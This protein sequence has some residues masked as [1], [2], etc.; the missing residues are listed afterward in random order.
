MRSPVIWYGGKSKLA[1]RIIRLF[2]AHYTYVEPCFGGGSVFFGKAPSRHEVVNDL[3]SDIVNFFRVLRDPRESGELKRRLSL[4]PYSREEHDDCRVRYN[5]ISD[6]KARAFF[7]LVR[8]SFNGIFRDSWRT[9][10]RC[11]FVQD[12]NR[13][14]ELLAELSTRLKC[15]A[16]E[17]RDCVEVIRRYEGPDTLIFID[18]PYLAQTRTQGRRCVF[19]C[20][21]TDADHERL[22]ANIVK[23][24]SKIILSGYASALY[25]EH[26]GDWRRYDLDVAAH[27]AYHAGRTERSRR[28][29]CLWINPAAH[30]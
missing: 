30:E 6:E 9:G 8:Q 20:E 12:F 1:D 24:Q 14:V 3:D 7:V 13:A 10:A 27:A 25:Q 15:A 22:L 5:Q 2:P 29:E 17:H 4:T 19:Q 28:T 11:N 16:I 21:M 26:L 18:P 23:S